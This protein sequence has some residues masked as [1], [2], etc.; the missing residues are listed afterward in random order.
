MKRVGLDTVGVLLAIV[1]W[2]TGILSGNPASLYNVGFFLIAG[3]AAGIGMELS[4]RRWE[5]ELC[6]S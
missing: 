1:F 6:E 2:A 3:P 5:R 4:N